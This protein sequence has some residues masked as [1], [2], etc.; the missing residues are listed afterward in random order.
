MAQTAKT[1][2]QLL[3]EGRRYARRALLCIQESN[4]QSPWSIEEHSL[5]EQMS[6]A[7][8]W[9]EDALATAEYR[10]QKAD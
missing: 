5:Q 9:F 7:L 1:P 10:E 4:K 8:D 3:L 2:R 6:R